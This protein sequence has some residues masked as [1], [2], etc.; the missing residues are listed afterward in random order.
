MQCVCPWKVVAMC[1]QDLSGLL[2]GQ[3]RSPPPQGDVW[4]QVILCHRRLSCARVLSHC[5]LGPNSVLSSQTL[6]PK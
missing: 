6:R 3:L 2:Y 4:G 5:P 1:T